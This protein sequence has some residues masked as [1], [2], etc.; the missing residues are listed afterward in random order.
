MIFILCLIIYIK[1]WK[2]KQFIGFRTIVFDNPS[3]VPLSVRMCNDYPFVLPCLG[4]LPFNG[5]H[6]VL[7]YM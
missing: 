2:F 6:W 5:Y 7:M 1:E 4:Y 3:D